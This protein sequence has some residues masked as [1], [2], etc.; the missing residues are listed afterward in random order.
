MVDFDGTCTAHDTTPL[1]PRLAAYA[2][3]RRR[4]SS[5]ATN[6]DDE[7]AGGEEANAHR[8]DL[9]RRTLQFQ[10]LEE[11]YF[12]LLKG[13]KKL[14]S[15]SEGSEAGGL[16]D[17]LDALDR[18]SN[19]VTDMVSESGVLMDLG[20][21][22]ACELGGILDLG[23]EGVDDGED[24]DGANN[25]D[26]KDQEAFE[27]VTVRLRKGCDVA[28]ARI[29]S[30]E[31]TTNR[32]E[33]DPPSSCEG[34]NLAVLSINWCPALIDAAL[35]RPVLE[36]T[37]G[38]LR[39][40]TCDTEVPVWS[41]SVDGDGV[42]SLH[43]P[44]AL[45]KR[46]RIVELRSRILQSSSA[47]GN[48]ACC[49]VIVY[50]GDSSTD[51]AALLEADVGILIGNSGTTTAMAERWGVEIVPL[52]HRKRYGFGSG[53]YG[54]DDEEK[55]LWRAESWQEIDDALPELDERLS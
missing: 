3:A 18:P 11:R 13:V 40:K 6:G 9:R 24:D 31:C 30:K 48:G 20:H 25:V 50:V 15:S 39:L 4:R 21:V 32:K 34:W 14:Q 37:Q 47:R 22:D 17:A 42:V 8:D 1:L 38:M 29:L 7:S 43:V 44:G 33:H 26:S 27:K 16:H 2:T 53:S 12:E 45:A 55:R 28:L 46:D 51:L 35:V 10:K 5:E 52:Q 49:G 23:T 36:K 41:N 54:S 19:L